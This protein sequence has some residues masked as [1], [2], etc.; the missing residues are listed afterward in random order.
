MAMTLRLTPEETEKLRDFA[1]SQERSMQEVARE[2]IINYIDQ[3]SRQWALN[4]AIDDLLARYPD[5]L[6]RLGQ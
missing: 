3:D 4:S 1:A 2:A 5:T 6:A